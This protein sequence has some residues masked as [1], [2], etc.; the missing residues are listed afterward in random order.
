MLYL[1]QFCLLPVFL[2]SR[3]KFIFSTACPHSMLEYSWNWMLWVPWQH[4]NSAARVRD[5]SS[6]VRWL[7][8]Y[9]PV[10]SQIYNISAQNW[11]SKWEM[12]QLHVK[13][14]DESQFL[15][16]TTV[17]VSIETLTQQISAIYNGRLK[18]DR[19]CSGMTVM[20]CMFTFFGF[21][22]FMFLTD[23]F[24]HK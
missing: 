2:I 21:G 13:R 10:K 7:Y 6:V 18:V 17:D 16:S 20:L 5:T 11:F 4:T 23:E 8:I 12:V 22:R 3:L 19:I 9:F 24:I 15:F 1:F 14:G